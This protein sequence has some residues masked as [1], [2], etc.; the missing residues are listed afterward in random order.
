[1]WGNNSKKKFCP[2]ANCFGDALNKRWCFLTHGQNLSACILVFA[3][4]GYLHLNETP[5]SCYISDHCR[6]NIKDLSLAYMNEIG[7]VAL[8]TDSSLW[9]EF[10]AWQKLQFFYIHCGQCGLQCSN[11]HVKYKPPCF[12][13]LAVYWVINT[14]THLP[15]CF[16]ERCKGGCGKQNDGHQQIYRYAQGKIWWEWQGKRNSR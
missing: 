15:Y 13:R 6:Y 16:L 8:V 1:M 12:P 10:S 7:A 4:P 14:Y 9:M 2:N 11:H 5:I 3:S